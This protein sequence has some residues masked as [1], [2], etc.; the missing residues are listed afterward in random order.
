MRAGH[1]TYRGRDAAHAHSR[2][3]NGGIGESGLLLAKR[4]VVKNLLLFLYSVERA[5][6]HSQ[7]YY[8]ILV[9]INS[10]F[11]CAL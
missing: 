7:A 4:S 8:S 2:L 5:S 11:S 1:G 3:G 6:S 9:H 10:I